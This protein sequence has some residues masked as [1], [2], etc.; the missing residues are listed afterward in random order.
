M[1]VLHNLSDNTDVSVYVICLYTTFTVH[2]YSTSAIYRWL[3]PSDNSFVIDAMWWAIE[4]GKWT[5]I[6]MAAKSSVHSMCLFNNV[7]TP[8]VCQWKHSSNSHHCKKFVFLNVSH[9][10]SF[11]CHAW[12]LARLTCTSSNWK[13][14]VVNHWSDSFSRDGHR[15]LTPVSLGLVKH[16]GLSPDNLK[17]PVFSHVV[18]WS[19]WL[20]QSRVW[21]LVVF[22]DCF[23][24]GNGIRRH[25]LPII[26]LGFCPAP[27]RHVFWWRI[28][29]RQSSEKMASSYYR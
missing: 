1:Y 12:P 25:Q 6:E 17:T 19:K 16:P 15:R 18:K 29:I 4:R 21:Q 13:L 9:L 14:I 24:T 11:F 20:G 28:G 7:F 10:L 8:L 2:T 26:H 3:S 27:H 5:V 23:G 22:I